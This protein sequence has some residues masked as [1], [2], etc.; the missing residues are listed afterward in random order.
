[1]FTHSLCSPVRHLITDR[2]LVERDFCPK[3]GFCIE[4]IIIVRPRVSI[5]CP[6]QPSLDAYATIRVLHLEDNLSDIFPVSDSPRP[7]MATPLNLRRRGIII[8]A[9]DGL[10]AEL[11]RK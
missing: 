11:A 4:I 3:I 9:S 10:G 1:M 6:L 8:G 7:A 5:T 2:A